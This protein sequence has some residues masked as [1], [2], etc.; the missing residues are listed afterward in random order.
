MLRKTSLILL[1]ALLSPVCNA[2]NIDGTL[3]PAFGDG[4]RSLFGYLATDTL[5][6]RAIAKYPASGRIWMFA[7]DPNDRAAI[8]IARTLAS[9]QPDTGF[10]PDLDGRRRT[11]LPAALIP[12][13]ESLA[14]DG[15]IIQADGKPVI[16]G[17]LQSAN[18][19]TGA[20]PAVVCRLAAAGGLDATFD[21]DGCRTVRSFLDNNERCRATDAAIAPN[22]S[23]VVIGNC[24]AESMSERPF[25][26][27]LN[28]NGNI[29]TEFGAGVGIVTP[30]LPVAS[31]F[32]QHYD[33][34]VIRPDGLIAVLGEFMMASN[35][36]F[37]VEL[38]LLQFD[39]G[40]SADI[41]FSGDG[42]QNFAFDVGGDNHDRARDLVLRADGKL[43]ALGEA[44]LLNPQATVALMAQVHADGSVDSEFGSNGKRV[45]DLDGDLELTGTLASLELDNLGRAIIAASDVAG[46]PQAN[47]DSGTDFWFVLPSSVPPEQINTVMIS[48]A[49]ATTG[50]ISSPALA[51]TYPFSVSPGAPT[52]VLLPPSLHT[53]S[54]SINGE[55]SDNT[56]HLVANAPVTV[57]PIHGRSF[58]LDTTVMLPV[59]QLGT[60]YRVM[61]WGAGIGA[62]S[63]L[64][65]VANAPNTKVSITPAV[66]AADHPAGVPYTVTLQTGDAYNLRASSGAD[67]SGSIIVADK[68]VAVFGG[69]TCAA[70]PNA[71]FD[72]CDLSYEQLQPLS[73]WGNT[74]AMVPTVDR[75]TGDV[76]R[77]LANEAD[78]RVF[79]NGVNI[80]TLMPGQKHDVLRS[81]ATIITTSKAA[82][83]AQFT[84]GCKLD[85]IGDD[86][87]GDPSM[88][89]LEPVT[90]WSTDQVAMLHANVG[91]FHQ[92]NPVLSIVAPISTIGT[93]TIDGV[94]L[95]A[96]AFT[97]ISNSGFAYAQSARLPG[98]YIV[99][100]DEPISVT[101]TGLGESE[102]Y[103]HRGAV[104]S[105][106]T[107]GAAEATADDV[108]LRLKPTGTRDPEF[109]SNGR[110]TISNAEYF[111]RPI[112]A[113]ADGDGIIVGTA[114]RQVEAEQDLMLSYRLASGSLFKDGFE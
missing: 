14:L 15:A 67:M 105:T 33:S 64:S 98:E 41:T 53:I 44:K 79:A 90:R 1:L 6:M 82:S 84:R 81:S 12:Q 110:V 111:D 113:F 109:G 103:A 60:H 56:L 45:D 13:L 11:V 52:L 104:L 8:Y 107:H 68:P 17:A 71:D 9:G 22:D 99:R 3:D 69:H 94:L 101:I 65:I 21:G 80:A 37:D 59:S 76:I 42:F 100:A 5:Q 25:V 4:G 73:H 88:L 91:N 24:V 92:R 87:P 26:T 85:V 75:T 74:F 29:D 77:I 16:F 78:T 20:F 23:I 2:A 112:R 61:A 63:F 27:R 50:V 10:G 108:V 48:S 57:V 58:S 31:A 28:A 47:A 39:N 89:T 55:I 49:V 66:L 30:Q 95:G 7:D 32:T 83:V 46:Q 43:L 51:E 38:G 96:G 86:C 62:G 70:V 93:V 114:V 40:G 18:G 102:A 19:E 35:S 72:F 34:V 106:G 36:I 97:T 54:N